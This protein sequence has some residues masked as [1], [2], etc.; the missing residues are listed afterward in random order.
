[1]Q[2]HPGSL[3]RPHDGQYLFQDFMALMN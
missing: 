2:Y 3:R 1:M